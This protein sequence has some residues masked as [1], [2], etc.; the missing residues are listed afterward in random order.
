MQQQESK[1]KKIEWYLS[2]FRD[3]RD[4]LELGS[5]H[6]S[7]CGAREGRWRAPPCWARHCSSFGLCSFSSDVLW[8]GVPSEYKTDLE[9]F[10]EF[11]ENIFCI[12]FLRI[13][14]LSKS[15]NGNL[16][17]FKINEEMQSE[18]E[19]TKVKK[20]FGINLLSLSF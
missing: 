19:T 7:T 20:L 12:I 17:E 3:E 15:N 16:W 2:E 6:N 9:I 13:Q 10:L 14:K 4:V 1:R 11:F 5:S 8:R 18:N